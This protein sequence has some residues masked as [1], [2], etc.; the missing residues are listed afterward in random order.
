MQE[1]EEAWSLGTGLPGLSVTGGWAKWSQPYPHATGFPSLCLS[2]FQASLGQ[3]LLRVEG[4]PTHMLPAPARGVRSPA[5]RP[6]GLGSVKGHLKPHT[7]EVTK[8]KWEQY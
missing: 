8:Q 6:R 4:A 2:F 5:G 1:T 3:I 7:E